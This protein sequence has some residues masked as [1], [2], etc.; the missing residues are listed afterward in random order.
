MLT[1][2]FLD[3]TVSIHEEKTITTTT[4]NH[5]TCIY[6]V[7]FTFFKSFFTFLVKNKAHRIFELN[8]IPLN[9]FYMPN[10]TKPDG[11]NWVLFLFSTFSSTWHGI[12][13]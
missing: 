7:F 11:T 6:N 2:I 5:C 12:F 3:T 1:I 10:S 9:I 4:C 8:N 13:G